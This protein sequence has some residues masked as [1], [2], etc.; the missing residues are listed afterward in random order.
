MEAHAFACYVEALIADPGAMFF[1]ILILATGYGLFG[2][3]PSQEN[4]RA[5]S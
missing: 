5:P 3:D 4:D 1:T 2:L